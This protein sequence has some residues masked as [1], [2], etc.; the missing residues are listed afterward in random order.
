MDVVTVQDGPLTQAPD[1]AS[2]HMV[3]S[4]AFHMVERL[5]HE[6]SLLLVHSMQVMQQT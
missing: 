2:S 5:T 3:W 4:A 6:G 1:E